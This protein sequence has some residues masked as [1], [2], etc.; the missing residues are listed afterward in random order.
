M[1]KGKN[2]FKLSALS[3][4]NGDGNIIAISFGV[5][6]RTFLTN[7]FGIFSTKTNSKVHGFQMMTFK[8][9]QILGQIIQI[10]G[11]GIF[12]IFLYFCGLMEIGELRTRN[13]GTSGILSIKNSSSLLDQNGPR[14]YFSF[15]N[16]MMGLIQALWENK[17]V[18]SNMYS[19]CLEKKILGWISVG[20]INQQID[21]GRSYFQTNL[22]IS[23]CSFGRTILYS[24]DGGGIYIDGGSYTM[25]V[26]CSMFYNCTCSLNGGSIYFNSAHSTLTMICANRC[27]C[28][29]SGSGHFA[30]IISSITNHVQFLS[31]SYCSINTIGRNSIRLETG[32]Q[33]FSNSNS[34]LNRADYTSGVYFGYPS[35]NPQLVSS[36]CTFSN[37]NVS[38]G[39]IITIMM[40]FF[41][42]TM[43]S[44]NIV[45]NN[46]PLQGVIYVGDGNPKMSYCILSWNRNTLFY[47]IYG[48]LTISHSIISHDYTF[49]T[50]SMVITSTNDSFG[51]YPTYQIQFL[52]SHYC[53]A[54][55][56]I[57]IPTPQ[58]TS[59]IPSTPIK[60]MAQT[61]IKTLIHTPQESNKET[62]SKT[63]EETMKMTIERT[64]EATMKETHARTYDSY[65]TQD[66][67]QRSHIHIVFSYS[68]TLFLITIDQTLI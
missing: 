12:I 20:C 19:H 57:I 17:F 33:I 67:G 36:Y 66:M 5:M 47:S 3:I 18:I 25:V 46:S 27:S 65:C 28:G 53:H 1:R 52:G 56:P 64:F 54:H 68:I 32:K 38:T 61:P 50:K 29:S 55:N 37:N 7:L 14:M 11:E 21:Q 51:I 41:A 24:G 44:T 58:K 15:T 10:V 48:Y 39:C 26:F 62:I 49:S 31:L 16:T 59:F 6:Y 30:L 4:K 35:S 43:S 9:N 22:D 40:T 63:N 13:L 42:G 34:S 60:T 2:L 45:H 8:K 23:Y